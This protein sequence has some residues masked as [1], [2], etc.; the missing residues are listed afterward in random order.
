MKS[1]ARGSRTMG[2]S[3]TLIVVAFIGIASSAKLVH[4]VDP[5]GWSPL[6]SPRAIAPGPAPIAGA[7]APIDFTP[8]ERQRVQ[9]LGPWPP[10]FTRDPSNRVSGNAHAIELG[11]RLFSDARMSPVGYLG[12]VTCFGL[13]PAGQ[14][15]ATH[16]S[17][18]IA[19]H[20]VGV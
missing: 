8:D 12:C 15:R 6:E 2:L 5:R 16:G 7:R 18:V 1:C 3:R 17:I 4:A 11:R 20:H 14:V 9:A 13:A 10:E 19:N